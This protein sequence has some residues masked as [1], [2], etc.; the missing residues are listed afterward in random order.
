MGTYQFIFH[1]CKIR[2]VFTRETLIQIEQQRDDKADK[3]IQLSDCVEVFIPSRKKISS[4]GFIPL[5]E[6]REA[7]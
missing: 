3:T 5:T 7:D 6:T 2:P 1:P 4:P